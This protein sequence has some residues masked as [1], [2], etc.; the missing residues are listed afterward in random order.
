MCEALNEVVNSDKKLV[1]TT[2]QS[3]RIS[4][5]YSAGNRHLSN[6]LRIDLGQYDYPV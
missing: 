3:R 5:K 6:L 1:I 4:E 2:D